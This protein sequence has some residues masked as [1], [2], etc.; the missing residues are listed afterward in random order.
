MDAPRS[1]FT[2]QTQLADDLY[3]LSAVIDRQIEDRV[4]LAELVARVADRL[5]RHVTLTAFGRVIRCAP[6]ARPLVGDPGAG[7]GRLI[8]VDIGVQI[9]PPLPEQLAKLV[10]QRIAH[11]SRVLLHHE[12]MPEEGR[13]FAEKLRWLLSAFATGEERRAI[14]REIGWD[15]QS[16]VTVLAVAGVG[17]S[18]D[19]AERLAASMSASPVVMA[20]VGEVLAVVVAGRPVQELD[21][22]EGMSVG[23]GEEVSASELH[24]SWQSALMALRF[25]MPSRRSRGPYRLF[26]AVIVDVA[27]IGAL[28]VLAD[29]AGQADVQELADV[30]G[31]TTLAEAVP[32]MVTVLEAVAATDSI[33]RAAQLVHMHHNTVAQRVRDAERALGYPLTE[34]YGRTRLMVGLIL[35]R[36]SARPEG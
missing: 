6:G 18:Q 16:R 14:R 30:R 33:R 4:S 34:P 1:L 36:L 15:D 25:S 35:Y 9:D 17:D 21:V 26:D 28:R 2:D 13:G 11:A 23:V 12:P 27:N 8:G 32:D 10:E 19:G 31:L 29:V 3:A 7:H 20:Y 24:A 22:P 5:R